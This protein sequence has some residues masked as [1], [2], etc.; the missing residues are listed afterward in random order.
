MSRNVADRFLHHAKT[1]EEKALL[2]DIVRHNEKLTF[3]REDKLGDRKDMNDPKDVKNIESKKK[4]GV[5]SYTVYT[6]ENERGK[7]KIG[8][9]RTQLGEAPYYVFSMRKK[10]D[11]NDHKNAV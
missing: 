2:T 10:R 11:P 1:K 9:E 4:R 3:L 6:L 8:F 5:L 7:W